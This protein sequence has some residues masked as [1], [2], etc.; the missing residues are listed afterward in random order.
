MKFL[1]RDTGQFDLV[2][3]RLRFGFDFGCIGLFHFFCRLS[4]RLL[5]VFVYMLALFAD[6]RIFG[7]QGALQF[8]KDTVVFCFKN[9]TA[10]TFQKST[11]TNQGRVC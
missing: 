4:Q 10:G 2:C 5:S 9:M 3:D 1:L 6:P 7:D 8:C 11:C